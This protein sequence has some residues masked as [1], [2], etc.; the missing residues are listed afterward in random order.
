[1]HRAGALAT[2]KE[3]PKSLRALRA[4]SRGDTKNQI[5]HTTPYKV[6][7]AKSAG[8]SS[9]FFRF[10]CTYFWPFAQSIWAQDA[11]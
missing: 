10:K 9:A 2:V 6:D 1:M 5:K 4:R 7:Y 11:L 3:L 8:N